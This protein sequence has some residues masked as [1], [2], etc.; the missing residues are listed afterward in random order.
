MHILNPSQI[1]YN[2]SNII[3]GFDLGLVVLVQ[4]GEGYNCIKKILLR[5]TMGAGESV[6]DLPCFGIYFDRVQ[7]VIVDCMRRNVRGTTSMQRVDVILQD[8]T[9]SINP[10]TVD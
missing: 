9:Q 8:V 1:R 6:L 10:S 5:T 3:G 2:A 4:L 7:V